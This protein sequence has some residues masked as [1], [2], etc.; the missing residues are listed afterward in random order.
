M[1]MPIFVTEKIAAAF[2]VEWIAVWNTRDLDNILKHYARDIEFTSPFVSRFMAD[3]NVTLRGIV[4]LQTY[5]ARVLK[6]YPNLRFVL[7]RVYTAPASVVI[8]YQTVSNRMAAEM[9]EFNDDGLVCRVRA[10]Y[11]AK[12][13]HGGE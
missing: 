12:D 1:D 6:A 11:A 8:E 7:R 13:F 2:A 10:H 5:F 9:M 4:A 3:G